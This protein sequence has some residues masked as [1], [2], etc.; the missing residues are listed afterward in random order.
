MPVIALLRLKKASKKYPKFRGGYMY[1]KFRQQLDA[2]AMRLQVQPPTSFEYEDPKFWKSSSH[3]SAAVAARL[4]DLKEWYDPA[5][6]LQTFTALARHFGSEGKQV[7]QDEDDYINLIGD[8]E[9]FQRILQEA[10]AAK[11]L[12]RIEASI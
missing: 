4:R 5:V 11:D 12:F 6:G 8:L 9:E 2:A 3:V 1:P 10:T 7:I